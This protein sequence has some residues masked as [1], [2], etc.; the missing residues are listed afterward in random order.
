M[1]K[2]KRLQDKPVLLPDPGHDWERA[3]VFNAAAVYENNHFHLFYR[4]SDNPFFLNCEKPDPARKFT[5]VIGHAVSKDGIHF[6]RFEKPVLKPSG[7][8]DSW[9]V[10][11]PRITKIDDTYYMVYTAFG[12]RD[13][14]DVRVSMVSSPDLEH[15]SE[16]VIL[17][18]GEPNKD[19]ALLP[20]KINNKYVLFHRRIPSIW[21]A[22]SD[23][24]VHWT[25]HRILM[26][27]RKGKWDSRKIGIAG[28]PLRIK[29]GWLLIYHGVDEN[30]IY[31]LGAA[32]LDPYD[33]NRVLA[34]QDEPILEPELDWEVNGLVPNVVFSCG[35]LIVN[36]YLYVYYGAADTY[37]GIAG[38]PVSQIN[39]G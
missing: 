31:R 36:D 30:N 20:E 1:F 5:S 27:P 34:R 39:F 23:D 12:G 6:V 28:P 29:D 32:L 17:L 7:E 25:E 18:P 13:W 22:V 26:T 2:L 9:G 4:A 16:S 24:L 38:I 35:N 14:D 33:I 11:D 19:A 21:T 10:E 37:M 15:W 3:A 8:N